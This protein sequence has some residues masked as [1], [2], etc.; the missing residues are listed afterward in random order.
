VEQLFGEIVPKNIALVF[1]GM[2]LDGGKTIAQTLK[3]KI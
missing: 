2:S 1:T 3:M